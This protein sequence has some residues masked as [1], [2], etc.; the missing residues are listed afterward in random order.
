MS[1]T[2]SITSLIGRTGCATDP[3]KAGTTIDDLARPRFGLV[4]SQATNNSNI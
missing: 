2:V 4:R 1:G 3:E